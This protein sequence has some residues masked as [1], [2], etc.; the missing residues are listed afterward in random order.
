M[1]K[2]TD[3]WVPVWDWPTKRLRD[4]VWDVLE[5]NQPIFAVQLQTTD[6][7]TAPI[8]YNSYPDMRSLKLVHWHSMNIIMYCSITNY[9]CENMLQCNTGVV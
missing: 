3:L 2:R 1:A 9:M 7:F 5:S 8:P 6:E 4:G